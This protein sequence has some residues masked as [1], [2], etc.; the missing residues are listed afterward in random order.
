VISAPELQSI[1]AR[2]NI[3]N[4][5]GQRVK[6]RQEGHEYVGCCPFHEEN[7]PSFKVDP[8]KNGGVY[9]CFGCGEKGDVFRFIQRSEG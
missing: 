2:A 3:L 1:R 8:N 5:I 4:I 9:I 7:T 6:L